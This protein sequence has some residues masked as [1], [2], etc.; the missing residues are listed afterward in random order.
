MTKYNTK[1]YIK[2]LDRYL[3]NKSVSCIFENVKW[4]RVPIL[5]KNEYLL[6]LIVE[7]RNRCMWWLLVHD[8][9]N[10]KFF[11]KSLRYNAQCLVK[12]SCK[13]KLK[14]C[15]QVTL[16]KLKHKLHTARTVLHFCKYHLPRIQNAVL[17][18]CDCSI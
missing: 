10:F 7:V 9:C 12:I 18:K 13:N 4:N 1:I 16:V 11:Q 17:V 2:T 14:Y 6:V 15:C 5:T 3:W 8:M